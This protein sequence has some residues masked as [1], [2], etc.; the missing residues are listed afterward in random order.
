MA[1]THPRRP[2]P[3]CRRPIATPA[4]KFA[5]HDPPNH[6]GIRAFLV[7]CTGSLRDAPPGGEQPLLPPF[8]DGVRDEGGA[9]QE[10][11]FPDEP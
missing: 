2:C 1:Y 4:G 7:S 9:V 8:D 5:R 3:V 11:L 10:G 6:G